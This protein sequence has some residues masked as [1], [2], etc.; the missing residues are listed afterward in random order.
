MSRLFQ[1]TVTVTIEPLCGRDV[2]H[3]YIN[4]A[5]RGTIVAPGGD[6]AGV[7]S[8]GGYVVTVDE[9]TEVHRGPYPADASWEAEAQEAACFLAF[10]RCCKATGGD[11][12]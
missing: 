11:D 10:S 4:G 1:R 6:L 3:V 12:E 2:A 5:K 8:R 7:S 9:R